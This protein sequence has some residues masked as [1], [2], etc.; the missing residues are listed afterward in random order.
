[1]LKKSSI[2]ILFILL[3]ISNLFGAQNELEVLQQLTISNGLAHNGVTAIH[4]DSKGYLWFATYDG[5][6]RYD[7]YEIKTYK[8]LIQKDILVSNRV[9]SICEDK[10]GNIWFGT[11]EGITVYNYSQENFRYVFSNIEENKGVRGPVIRKIIENTSN[12]TIVCISEN[13]GLLVFNDDYTFSKQYLPDSAIEFNDGFLLDKDSYI[14]SANSG[15][16]VFNIVNS[17]FKQVLS[18]KI[19]MTTSIERAGKDL[20]IVCIDF[21]FK[22]IEFEKNNTEYL[23][24]DRPVELSDTQFKNVS[25]ARDGKIWLSALINGIVQIDNLDLLRRGKAYHKSVYNYGTGLL[26]ASD[27]LPDAKSGCWA[28]TFNEGVFKI[29]TKKN[30]FQNY[31]S[32][33]NYKNGLRS[34]MVSHISSYDNNKILMSASYGGVAIYDQKLDKFEKLPFKISSPLD[35][36][37][38]FFDKKRNIW[39]RKT[40]NPIL[41]Y[42]K[43][44]TGKIEK[45]VSDELTQNLFNIRAFAEDNYGNVWLASKDN[46]LRI[47]LNVSNDILKVESLVNHSYFKNNKLVNIRYIYADPLYNFIWICSQSDG[48]LRIKLTKGELKNLQV[49]QYKKKKHSAKSISSNFVS[50]IIRLPNNE[51]WLGT[52]GGGICKVTNSNKVPE[53]EVFSEKDGLS[54]N[55]VKS[56]Q[57]DNFHN[58]WIATNIGLNKF[59]TKDKSFKTYSV[60]DGLPFDDFWY[61]SIRLDNGMLFF[62]GLDGVCFFNPN[63]LEEKEDIPQLEFG[64]LTVLNKPIYPGDTVNNR[65]L[66]NRRLDEKEEIVLDYNENTFSIELK[67]LHFSNAGN[68]FLRYKL[69]PNNSDWIEVTSDQRVLN[70]SSLQPGE[71][72]L[73]AM[74]SNSLNEWTKPKKIRIIITPPFWKTSFAYFSYI[75]LLLLIIWS[76]IMYIFRYQ[77]L[78]YSLQI[79]KLEKDKVKEVNAAK[80]RFFSNI[81]HEIKTPIALI[82]GPVDLL[83]NRFV[84]NADVKEKLQ[85][86]Q[87]QSKKISQLVDQV[88]DFQRSDASKL[89]MNYTSFG[90]ESF[91]LELLKDFEFMTKNTNKSLEINSECENLFVTADKDKL[92]KILNNLLN[93]ACKFTKANDTISVNYTC[94]NRELIIKVKDTGR[95]ISEDDL[96]HIFERFYQSSHKH[97]AYIGGSGI[98]LAFTKRLVEMHYGSICAESVLNEGTTIRISLPIIAETVNNDIKEREAELLSLEEQSEKELDVIESGSLEEIKLEGD[99]SNISIFLAEDN[100]ELRNFIGSSL[101]KFFKIKTFVN[102]YECLNALDDEWPDLIISDILMPE[103]NGLELCRHIKSDI[104][105]SHIPVILLTACTSI[106]DQIKGIQEG[107]DSYMK[108]PFNL[109]H[110]IAK[111]EFLLKSRQKL[112]ERFSI[113]LPLTKENAKENND[114][115]IFLEKLYQLMAD[116]LDNQDLDLNQFAKELY[117]NRTHFYQKVKALTNQTPFEL[118]KAYRLKKAAEFLVQNKLSVNEVYMMTGFKSRTHFSKLFKEKYQITPGKYAAELAKKYED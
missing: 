113:D 38:A 49:D 20:C 98:G 102:G 12:N 116:N 86:V 61:A 58:L 75:V 41:Y 67:S 103:L 78:N 111:I 89:K 112:R 31:N 65:I 48:L 97:G 68:H 64:E 35:I 107:A 9:R 88:H 47:S 27:I 73:Q 7:G 19:K 1:M 62:S 104:K 45:I 117:L 82:S 66:L 29:K 22:L 44:S 28:A 84:G 85:L 94:N 54:N 101:S 114:D 13:D 110:L 10:F 63:D 18:D 53:F 37:I 74:A 46:V 14:L 51:L 59:N 60:D 72:E 15:L 30:F 70:Y 83:L 96:P 76:V 92:E 50:N 2:F 90:F 100:H 80:L 42:I 24:K 34:N 118:L 93:N 71:Y 39:L 5:I 21:G 6:N 77:K 105:T 52:E 32:E 23:F 4:E 17:E 26:R 36:N 43:S 55:V 69:L 81:S 99:F 57:Y 87:R 33:M 79:E 95:G 3:Q 106:D 91:L 16:F 109:K 56:I 25:I 115:H 108:K 40:G 11:D 8:N